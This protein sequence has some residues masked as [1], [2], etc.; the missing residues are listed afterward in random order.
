MIRVRDL[1]ESPI[2]DGPIWT[3]TQEAH[4]ATK[5]VEKLRHAIKSCPSHKT[6]Q[7]VNPFGVGSRSTGV[8]CSRL[9]EQYIESQVHER[10]AR[11]VRF[12]PTRLSSPILQKVE[13]ARGIYV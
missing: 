2:L 9:S 4:V 1:A 13:S 6:S 12:C 7:W 3:R 5:Y 10:A 8:D 11:N